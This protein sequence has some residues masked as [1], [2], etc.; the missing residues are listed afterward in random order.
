VVRRRI[1]LTIVG[2]SLALLSLVVSPPDAQAQAQ[3]KRRGTVFV[4]G[5]FY[6]PSFGP[7]PWWPSAAYPYDYYP[8]F[9]RRADVRVLVTPKNAGVYVDGYYA[10]VVGDF[11]GLF[12]RL[13]LPPYEHE[14]VIY[15]EGYRTAHQYLSL[16][17]GGTY[18]VQLTM[19][20]LPGGERS[21]PPD[22][23][24]PVPPPPARSATR[25]R[26][27]PGWLRPPQGEP[28]PPPPLADAPRPGSV[29]APANVPAQGGT[30]SPVPAGVEA[31][32]VLSIRVQP[33]GAEIIIDGQPWGTT[34]DGGYHVVQVAEDRHHVE[35]RKSGY[36]TYSADI[37]VRRGETVPLNVS[38]SPE[39][40]E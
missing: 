9:E 24:P 8:V 36:K 14:I 15:L 18:K 1:R 35:I 40:S 29:T 16:T 33:A 30:R 27:P 5:Y 17:P 12:E 34:S 2:A 23:A 31:F 4:G 26:T 20:R 21:E 38:L 22:V 10:G 32:G 3:V 37:E 6:D 28:A 11:N 39:T 7:Y 13:P 25:P 19:E